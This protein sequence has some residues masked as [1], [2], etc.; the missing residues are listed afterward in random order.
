MKLNYWS[1]RRWKPTRRTTPRPLAASPSPRV[2]ATR[3]GNLEWPDQDQCAGQI[4]PFSPSIL[5]IYSHMVKKKRGL[6]AKKKG[7][8]T[9]VTGWS[10]QTR[11]S[12]LSAG[13]PKRIKTDTLGVRI[14]SACWFGVSSGRLYQHATMLLNDC[15]RNTDYLDK[16]MSNYTM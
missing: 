14:G 9:G 13:R 4:S 11:P 10:K 12:K 1:I 3:E 8:A 5:L 7:L 15:V 6:H 16:E 2:I